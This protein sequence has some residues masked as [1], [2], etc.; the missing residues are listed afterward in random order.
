MSNARLEISNFARYIDGSSP[1]EATP[2]ILRRPR[3]S[4]SSLAHA[5][6]SEICI[7]LT[8]VRAKGD[9]ALSVHH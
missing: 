8:P 1:K 7:G 4:L 6:S 2:Q 3:H 5:K 9:A